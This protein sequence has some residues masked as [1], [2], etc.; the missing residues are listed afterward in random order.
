[1]L[2]EL[3]LIQPHMAQKPVL[4]SEVGF[5]CVAREVSCRAQD[6]SASFERNL[7]LRNWRRRCAG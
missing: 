7:G 6:T 5:A 4:R 1:M 3:K 2:V